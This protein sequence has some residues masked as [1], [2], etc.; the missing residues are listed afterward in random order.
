MKRIGS[1]SWLI[2]SALVLLLG[3]GRAQGQSLA[4][5]TKKLE[6]L[7]AYPDII[8]VNGRIA[9]MDAQLTQVQA[10]AIRN[11]RIL[12]RGSNDEIRFLAGPKTQVLDA[13]GRTVLPGMIDTHTHPNSQAIEHWLGAEGDFTSK[14]YNDPQLKIVLAKGNDQIEL[15]R[16]LERVVRQRAQELGPGKWIL[17][18]L[19]GKN[20]ISESRK[21]VSPLLKQR[22]GAGTINGEFLDML[23][24][25]NPV[26]VFGSERVGGSSHNTKAKELM[27]KFIGR[28]VFSYTGATALVYDILF[29]G[30]TEEKMDF[31]KRELL[32]CVVPQ[33]ITTYGNYY[34]GSPSIMQVHRL[35]SERGELPVR[36]A[37][38]VGGGGG[39]PLWVRGGSSNSI[40]MASLVA[41]YRF[42]GDLGDSRGIGNDYLWNAGV[43]N[44]EFDRTLMCTTA[45][46]AN[47]I[48]PQQLTSGVDWPRPDCNPANY[49]TDNGYL[50]VRAGLEAGLRIGFMHTYSDGSFDALFHMLEQAMAEGKLTLEQVR[51]LRVTTEHVPIIRPDQIPKIVRYGI[52]PSFTSYM[53][54][55]DLKGGAFLKAYGQEYMSW[56]MPVK[57]LVDAGVH[58]GFGSDAHLH[59]VPAEWKDMDWPPQWDGNI[60]AFMEFFANRVMPHEGITYNKAEAI[61]K[62]TL[63]KVM[64][65]WGAEQLLNEKNIGSLEVG[66]LADF[67]VIDK[68]YFTIPENQI[69]TINVLLTAVGGKTVY[70]HPD[71]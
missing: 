43:S 32:E 54:Q 63:M 41:R 56:I 28:E 4:D 20:S 1:F 25:D 39:D 34:Y 7:S 67:I 21:I 22:E 8:V 24:P 36:W 10:L 35:L 62:V 13:K 46:P 69:H 58:P 12:A 17:V 33:G 26:V 18:G 14:K 31:L 70:K 57:S 52:M 48:N 51:A 44:E 60:W 2:L 65:I 45:K 5:M 71:F 37:Y 6:R 9:T 42:Y 55:G 19:F 66:K 53:V 59:K 61:D 23:A 3:P 16:S 47:P 50:T 15:L 29:R 38:W 27:E 49:E 40:P 11:S 64:T 68:D 30:R